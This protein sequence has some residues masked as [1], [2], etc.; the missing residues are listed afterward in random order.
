MILKIIELEKVSFSDMKKPY[1]FVL[2]HCLRMTSIL[3]LIETIYL[4]HK[5]R[6]ANVFLYFRNVH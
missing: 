4:K 6:F 3:F 1:N 5:K 2:T